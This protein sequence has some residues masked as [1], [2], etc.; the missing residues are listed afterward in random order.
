MIPV[1]LLVCLAITSALGMGVGA[2]ILACMRDARYASSAHQWGMRFTYAEA[3]TAGAF[4]FITAVFVIIFGIAGLATKLRY[5]FDD[6]DDDQPRFSRKQ[7]QT[8]AFEEQRLAIQE[9]AL[10]TQ[11]AYLELVAPEAVQNTNTMV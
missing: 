5:G 9:R 7:R 4:W 8:I 3:M 6:D 11:R 10:S 1:E 2:G